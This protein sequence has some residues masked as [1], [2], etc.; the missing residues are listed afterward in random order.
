MSV[1]KLFTQLLVACLIEFV[2]HGREDYIAFVRRR[3][4]VF[5]VCWLWRSL[6][7]STAIMWN[8]IQATQRLPIPTLEAW[9]SRAARPPVYVELKI[10]NIHWYYRYESP[11]VKA[12]G[13][14]CC[15]LRV[16]A[17]KIE[18]WSS[19]SMV[20][21]DTACIWAAMDLLSVMSAPS[22]SEVVVSCRT[23]YFG[24]RF[25]D[26]QTIPANSVRLFSNGCP[27]LTKLSVRSTAFDWT[28][29]QGSYII[30]VARF[31]DSLPAKYETVSC[32][33]T[34]S[35]GADKVGFGF[36][37]PGRSREDDTGCVVG[38][39]KMPNLAMLT[40]GLEEYGLEGFSGCLRLDSGI[41]TD[42]TSL[43]VKG[44]ASDWAP[45]SVARLL[46]SP[47]PNV[48]LDLRINAIL[49]T[50]LAEYTNGLERDSCGSG[51]LLHQLQRLTN[52]ATQLGAVW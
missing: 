38:N 43:T 17:E 2:E 27:S 22:L 31:A 33:V 13:Y 1:N 19:F 5:N 40:I 39:F 12:V 9:L 26:S 21:E 10:Q 15:A 4:V 47:F 37:S 50:R 14:I 8:H 32:N 46:F 11:S 24:I 6:V 30:G 20:M 42:V 18:Q 36:N 29:F 44:S 7:T 25:L 48:E 3:G 35:D 28:V 23:L 34:V 16:L 51:F 49:F 41:F 45:L 52:V